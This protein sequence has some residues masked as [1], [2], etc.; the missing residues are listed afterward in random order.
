ME[1]A[2][3]RCLSLTGTHRC[4]ERLVRLRTRCLRVRNRARR[5]SARSP[6]SLRRN[7]VSP[8]S[9]LITQC[10]SRSA[11]ARWACQ[12]ERS[13]AGV[14][15]GDFRQCQS[16]PSVEPSATQPQRRLEGERLRGR[17]RADRAIDR[18]RDSPGPRAELRLARRHGDDRPHQRPA[19]GR[20]A[21]CVL[22]GPGHLLDRLR[23]A[24]DR[25]RASPRHRVDLIAKQD[26]VRPVAADALR[27]RDRSR[28]R[29]SRTSRA[30]T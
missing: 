23:G 12:T 9:R 22:P 21:L 20:R 19:D 15:L 28:P 17:A 27:A 1:S 24:P 7:L 30:A 18:R 11:P 3:S 2:A 10:V 8:H 26:R 14:E 29:S 6:D 25:H 16:G 4:A 13:G 5:I